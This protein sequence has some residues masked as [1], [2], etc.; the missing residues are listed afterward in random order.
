LYAALGFLI[1]GN[2]F[3]KPNISTLVGRMYRPDDPRR[4]GAFTIF[5]M[6]INAGAAASPLVCGW[7]RQKYGFHYGFAAAGVGM[8]IGLVFF[9]LGQKQVRSD[10]E[11]AGN[12]MGIA[13]REEPA[14]SAQ[15]K[16]HDKQEE[17]AGHAGVAGV[18]AQ[19]V[20]F[21]LMILG[22][23]I[24]VLEAVAVVSGRA[25][26]RDVLM[27]TAFSVV[28][29]WMGSLLLKIRGAARD[30]STVIFVLFGFTVLFWMAFEQA[31]N[32]L[33]IWADVHTDLHVAGF[34]YPAEWWQFVNP[35]LIVLLAPLFSVLWVL[36]AGRGLEPSTPAKMCI[37]MGL[38]ALSF[39][40]MVAAAQAE[41]QGTTR[42]ALAA[43]PDGAS[44]DKINAGRLRFD[45][46]T[47]ELEV[48]GVLAPFA[49][50]E[51]LEA[52]APSSYK[53]EL[54]KM[55]NADA[56]TKKQLLRRM[57]PPA[58]A[59]ALETLSEKSNQSRASGF[60]LFLSYLLA[61]LGELCL[62]PVGLSMV[63]KLAPARFASLFM[64][65]WLL[66]SSVAQYAGG[67]LGEN[68]GKVSPTS[69]FMTFVWTSCVGAALLVL[70][71]IPLKRLM[72]DAAR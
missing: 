36:L 39:G 23:V 15:E 27:P 44:L 9:L 41:N 37:A 63:T 57:T 47:H 10:V 21:L 40:A 35:T 58:Y 22:V 49:V 7:L 54:E 72:H 33:N 30:K 52:V 5:Y 31:G 28:A 50:T 67:T 12:S 3:F 17:A 60:W 16:E 69:Y 53:A 55:P 1:A 64:G 71:V 4:N 61:T 14:P 32:A 20:P 70:L 24:P 34:E 51:A 66:S 48:R 8:V 2:G 56:A 65:V 6:G 42:V 62:S 26:L 68:W 11:A 13:P 25:G 19:V 29:I 38:M 18:I 46:S 43:I 45:A 59:E